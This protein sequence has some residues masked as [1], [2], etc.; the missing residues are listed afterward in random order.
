ML[1]KGTNPDLT[2]DTQLGKI[3]VKPSDIS[4]VVLDTCILIAQA[5]SASSPQR[6]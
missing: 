1:D 4:Y 6:R 3:G 2:I 5:R